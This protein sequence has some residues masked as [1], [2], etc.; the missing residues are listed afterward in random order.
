[1]SFELVDHA[2]VRF[3][4]ESLLIG[5]SVYG[6]E[7]RSGILKSFC[8]GDEIL[9][10]IE[11]E[12]RLHGNGNAYGC[13]HLLYDPECGIDIDHQARSVSALDDFFRWASHIHVDSRYS[14]SLYDFRSFTE[15][16]RVFPEYLDDE[17]LFGYIV[18]EDRFR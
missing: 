15:H 18:G 1:M 11:T 5:P 10:I 14:I 17:G 16:L 4:G 13:R 9:R 8:E 7:V 2:P 12:P 6:K 3:A